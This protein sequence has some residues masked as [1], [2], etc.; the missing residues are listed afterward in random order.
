MGRPLPVERVSERRAAL[1]E[2]LTNES[3]GWSLLETVV[4]L[5]CEGRYITCPAGLME[6]LG[7]HLHAQHAPAWRLRIGVRT[8]HPEVAA[9]GIT[10]L[11]G[12]GA[13]VNNVPHGFERSDDYVGSPVQHVFET[14]RPLR[15]RLIE[16]DPDRDHEVLHQLS[17]DGGTDY[18]AVP[19]T[20]STGR[21]STFAIATDRPQGFSDQDIRQLSALAEFL[22]PILEVLTTQH[23]ARTLLDT[24]VGH[25]TG[26]KVLQGLIKRGDAETIKAA[27][28]F[29]DLRDFTAITESLPLNQLMATLNAYFELIAAAVTARGGEI[30]RFI[31]DAMLIVFPVE[32]EEGI[33]AACDSALDS[34]IDAF[35]NLA[36]LNH[37][38]QRKGELPIS[39]GVG[40]HFGEVVY[41]N[42]GA[43]DRLDFTVMGAAVNRTARLEGL[44]KSVG[45]PLLMSRDFAR[46]I[47]P[48]TRSVG[49]YEMKGVHLPQEVFTLE[50]QPANPA[51]RR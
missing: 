45:H 13:K 3:P 41:G 46:L 44:T 25:R 16:L 18:L 39:F 11:R 40:L 47:R 42:V 29:S 10:W 9:L 31:G 5:F 37:R 8:L 19:L 43:P 7:E 15:R 36:A 30:L 20:F 32:Q 6:R 51:P 38:R 2:S 28:W 27:L 14:G 21:V 33:P 4:W 12:H 22:A 49:S 50:P 35:D 34:A 26:S 17:A 24:Y 48:P 23:L 1:V